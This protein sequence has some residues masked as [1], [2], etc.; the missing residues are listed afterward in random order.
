[1]SAGVF[2]PL[3]VLSCPG[4]QPRA[5]DKL[6]G[7][8]PL[9]GSRCARNKRKPRSPPS[10]PPSHSS[11]FPACKPSLSP[12]RS[13]FQPQEPENKKHKVHEKRGGHPGAARLGEHTGTHR[14]TQEHT[15]TRRNTHEHTRTHTNSQRKRCPPRRATTPVMQHPT[16]DLENDSFGDVSESYCPK[17]LKL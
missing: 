13:R 4:N 17:N 10:A 2:H 1:M 6:S 5:P 7:R 16:T 12:R 9:L 8:L 11:A 14:N 15:R 3:E